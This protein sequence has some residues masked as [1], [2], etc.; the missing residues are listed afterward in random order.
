VQIEESLSKIAMGS[1]PPSLAPFHA[2]HEIYVPVIT[3]AESVD[4][5]LRR[6]AVIFITIPSVHM[7]TL[8]DWVTPATMPK[9]FADLIRIVRATVRTRW[10]VLEPKLTEVRFGKLTKE[11]CSAAV[12]A[13][14]AS[15]EQMGREMQ[16]GSPMGPEGFNL[17]FDR[18][19]RPELPVL[20]K[21]FTEAV[22]ALNSAAESGCEEVA[23]AMDRLLANNARWAHLAARQFELIVRDLVPPAS[24]P[25]QQ[26]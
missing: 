23:K 24:A 20:W 14:L 22:Q 26:R 12:A 21:D 11:Q 7:K 10:D 18:S 6:V 19:L 15:Y 13:L 1:L 3:R 16:Q 5:V 8:A 4:D 25:T 9:S 2:A 17:I